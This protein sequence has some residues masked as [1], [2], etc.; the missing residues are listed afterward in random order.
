MNPGEKWIMC[1]HLISTQFFLVFQRLLLLLLFLLLSLLL[2]ADYV[3]MFVYFIRFYLPTSSSPLHRLMFLAH[4]CS[5]S[6][7][8]NVN[9]YRSL[10]A[11]CVYLFSPKHRLMFAARHKYIE[12]HIKRPLYIWRIYCTI[13][14]Y[15]RSIAQV[16]GLWR[17]QH[18]QYSTI[19]DI[20]VQW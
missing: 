15:K 10:L 9:V 2:Y 19:E 16:S 12:H 3:T 11:L 20:D 13:A 6:Y 17:P 7:R 1:K 18:T 4:S 5:F 14:M 8:F